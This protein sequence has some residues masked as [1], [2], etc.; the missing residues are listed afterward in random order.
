LL[1]SVVEAIGEALGIDSRRCRAFID[2]ATSFDRD[3]GV[4]RYREARMLGKRADALADAAFERDHD[5]LG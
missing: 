1:R 3:D 2:C 4:E 5:R